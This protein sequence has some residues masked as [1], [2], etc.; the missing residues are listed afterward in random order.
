MTDA[1]ERAYALIRAN[2]IS[3][4]FASGR[5][6]KSEELARTVG[7]SRTPVR[8]ALRRLHSEG[9]ISFRPNYGAHVTGWTLSDLDDVFGLRVV[10]ESY[11]AE[12][13][14]GKLTAGEID[15]IERCARA[16]HSLAVE[17]PEGFRDLIAAANNRLHAIIIGAAASRRLAAMMSGVM[18]M[19]LIMRTLWYYSDEDLF[20][21]AG[22]HAELVSAF[23][24]QDPQWAASVMRSH[25]LAALH[26]MRNATAASRPPPA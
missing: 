17:K 11:A 19:P 3:G 8:E 2:I 10:L 6:L 16:T 25:L 12:L 7:V 21:S 5:H 23:R 18:E 14:A 13:A 15:E 9:L 20:R 1:V 26:V 22:H 24:A 4:R